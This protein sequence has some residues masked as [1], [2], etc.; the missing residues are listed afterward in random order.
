M[1]A[2]KTIPKIEIALRASMELTRGSDVAFI[3]ANIVR[4]NGYFCIMN[5]LLTIISVASLCFVCCA[6]K[7]LE[8]GVVVVGGGASGVAAGIQSARLGETTL[9][10]EE[11]PWLGGMLTSAGVSAIDGNYRLRAGIFGE[12]CDSLAVRYGGYEALRTGWVS[13]ILFEPCVGEDVLENMTKAEPLLDVV[14]ESAFEGVEKVEGGWKVRSGGRDYVCKVLIDGTELGDVASACG[15]DYHIG[16]DSR[17]RTGEDLALEEGNDI[18]QDMTWVAVLKDYGPG[19]DMTIPEPEG[20]CRENYVNCCLNP[21]NTAVFEKNQTLW[22][23]EMM[24]SYGRLP[25]GE[26]MLN[27]PVEAN[28]YYANVIEM[29]REARDSV[30]R[31]AMN[32]TLGYVYFIQT[33]LGYVNYGLSDVEFPGENG[34]ALIPYHRESRRIEGEALVTLD[35]VAAPYDYG[36]ALYRT[37]VAVG[38]YP[39]DHH[40]FANPDWKTLPKFLFAPIPS[41]TVPAGTMVPVGVE[42]LIVIEKSISASNLVAGATRLQ[43]VVMELGQ[44][45]GV[46]AALAASSLCRVRDVSVREVQFFL[47]EQGARLQPYLDL[48]PGDPDFIALQKV[49]CTGIL[50]AEGRNVDWS[51]EMWMRVNDPLR[52]NEVYLKDYYGIDYVDSP[53]F[54]TAGIMYPAIEQKTGER[55]G[56]FYADD[57]D[58][59]VTRL[60]AIRAI[61]AY[62]SPFEEIDV[63]WT[64]AL[65]R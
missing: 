6:P 37:G 40:H 58:R 34:L 2:L 47:L 33:E 21:L 49:G 23:P 30:Y 29:D 59:V 39:V 48:D 57:P 41:F 25:G 56:R 63:D 36:Q 13:N 18:V 10:L 61:D 65:K 62:L 43:P 46:M 50:R 55:L 7:T 52:W 3:S 16:M 42:D 4:N 54:I 51:N 26:I 9:I 32:R 22:T 35:A 45:A 28:D 11:T 12:F 17:S 19:V 53:D 15:V 8:Y 14:K 31:M 20:Y 27:W 5:R 64:G 1:A 44:A 38:D 60:E 24:L